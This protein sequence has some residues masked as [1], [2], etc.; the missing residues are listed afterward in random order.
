MN[1]RSI[2]PRF[3]YK[4]QGRD[5]RARQGHARGRERRNAT[6]MDMDIAVLQRCRG[7]SR[8]SGASPGSAE[9]ARWTRR[10]YEHA[11]PFYS[12][13]LRAGRVILHGVHTRNIPRHPGF[14]F[15]RRGITTRGYYP[16]TRHYRLGW[17]PRG[18]RAFRFIYGLCLTGI[19]H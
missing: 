2:S 7:A 15:H 12:P 1:A 14:V 16:R 10:P 18:L 13:A 19:S 11:R 3:P 8:R 9:D 6:I 4:F 17:V 5:A